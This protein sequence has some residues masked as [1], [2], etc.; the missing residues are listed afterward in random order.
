MI[1]IPIGIRSSAIGLKTCCNNCRNK[2]L[3]PIIKEKKK[4]HSKI[5]LLSK[6]KLNRIERL[7]S[8]ALI[9]SDISHDESFLINNVLKE[10]KEMK[11]EIKNVKN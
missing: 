5:A 7:N 11:E 4:K 6:S 10:Y 8:K 9:D 1:G 2:R 3:K